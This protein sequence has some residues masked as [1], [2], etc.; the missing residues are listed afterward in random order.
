M[1]D[2]EQFENDYLEKNIHLWEK[3]KHIL[4]KDF[5]LTPTLMYR[6][7]GRVQNRGFKHFDFRLSRPIPLKL[8]KERDYIQMYS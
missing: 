5:V 4:K 7:T 2:D 8:T 3:Y 1:D 6:K